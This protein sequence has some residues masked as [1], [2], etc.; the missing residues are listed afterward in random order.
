MGIVMSIDI[1]RL[2]PITTPPESV[3][4]PDLR[5]KR[6]VPEPKVPTGAI[7]PDP[8]RWDREERRQRRERRRKPRTVRRLE[9][10]S[11]TD[12]RKGHIIDVEA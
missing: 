10:R 7:K 3:A 6:A 12:R 2:N 4:D 1:P 8:D 5:V 9:L 11:G